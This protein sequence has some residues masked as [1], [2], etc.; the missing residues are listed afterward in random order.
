MNK[1]FLFEPSPFSDSG[2]WIR[3]G[4]H[5]HT[6]NSDGGMTPEATVKRYREL[7]F[8]CVGITDHRQVTP[9][10]VFSEDTFVA[11]D[12]IENGGEPEIIGVGVK[13]AVSPELP[14]RERAQLLAR[15]GGFTIAGHPTYCAATPDAYLACPDLMAMEIY[16]AYCQEAYANG[17]ATELWDM[18]LGQGKRIWGVAGDDAHLNPRKRYYSDAGRA[19]VEVWAEQLSR[20]AI[21][22]ALKR[23]SFYSTQGPRFEAIAIGDATIRLA[24]SPVTEVR[25]R[26][27]GRV[28][29]VDHAPEEG[30]LTESAL[31][32]W[33]KPRL[34]VRIELVDSL[35]RK[36]WSNPIFIRHR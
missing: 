13:E 1:S 9:T 11:I 3:A 4:F 19:W 27:F 22:D 20:G 18:V 16:N 2:Q 30:S 14:L 31:P 23:G 17:L 25:W 36:A 21:L 35:G 10:G 15:Q 29:F 28:G 26:T 32:E 7:G 12:S 34:Y 24:C 33:Y 8:Q 5:C 6:V